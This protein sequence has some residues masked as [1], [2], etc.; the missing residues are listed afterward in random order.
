MEIIGDDTEMFGA[1]LTA[2]YLRLHHL[3]H[4][5]ENQCTSVLVKYIKAPVHLV[6]PF[7]FLSI[8]DSFSSLFP[9]A[10]Y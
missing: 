10:F 2:Q 8:T 4:C 1:L 7:N 5:K 3:H 9:F 6:R